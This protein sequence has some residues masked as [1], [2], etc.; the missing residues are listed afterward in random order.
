MSNLTLKSILQGLRAAGPY[1]AVELIL[2]GGTLVALLM[3]LA[4]RKRAS[5]LALA[6]ERS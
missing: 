2:P 4:Q 6:P 1:L 3:W 5:M